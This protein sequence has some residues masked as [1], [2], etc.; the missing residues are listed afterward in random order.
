MRREIAKKIMR[1]IMEKWIETCHVKI[2]D[3]VI[4]TPYV[5]ESII[6]FIEKINPKSVFLDESFFFVTKGF[7]GY[8]ANRENAEIFL[9]RR[10]NT[11]E[12]KNTIDDY[13][14]DHI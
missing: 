9:F 2:H 11:I 3:V 10:N 7:V 5:S 8:I 4:T 1:E 6:E 13:Q 14:I 12:K